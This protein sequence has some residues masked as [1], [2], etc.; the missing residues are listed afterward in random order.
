M[1]DAIHIIGTHLTLVDYTGLLAEIGRRPSV[2]VLRER[3]RRSDQLRG[4]PL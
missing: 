1:D 2:R 4:L 3:A